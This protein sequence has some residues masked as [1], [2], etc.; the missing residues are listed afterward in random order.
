[1]PRLLTILICLLL[2]ASAVVASEIKVII[3]EGELRE[4]VG[5]SHAEPG[6]VYL[7]LPLKIENN[8]YDSVDFSPAYCKITTEGFRYGDASIGQSL[9]QSGRPPLNGNTTLKNGENIEGYMAFEIPTGTI[10]YALT[11]Q[12]PANNSYKIVYVRHM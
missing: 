7:I 6:K 8:G 10:K 4:I 2:L 9:A 11:F 3:G 1:M 12:P 5:Y